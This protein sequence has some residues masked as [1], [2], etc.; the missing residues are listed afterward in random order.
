MISINTVFSDSNF[1]QWKLKKNF[2]NEFFY[3][4]KKNFLLSD[5]FILHY[6]LFWLIIEFWGVNRNVGYLKWLLNDF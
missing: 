2:I 3:L 1:N 4:L 5:D 6:D